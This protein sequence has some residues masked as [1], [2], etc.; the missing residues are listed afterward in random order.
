MSFVALQAR[1]RNF[2]PKGSPSF[3]LGPKGKEATGPGAGYSTKISVP[4]PGDNSD[5]IVITGTKEGIE[6]AKHEIQCISDEQV[7]SIFI[8]Q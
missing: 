2:H 5:I 8:R 3:I 4:R 1:P 7:A 6:K